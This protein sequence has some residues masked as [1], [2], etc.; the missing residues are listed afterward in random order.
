MRRV[1]AS[2][3]RKQI[4]TLAALLAADV[5]VLL[6]GFMIVRETAPVGAATSTP[7]ANCQSI[8]AE[9]LAEHNLAGAARLDADGGLRFELSGRDASG[10]LWPHASEVAWDA[11]PL[12]LALPDAGCGPYPVARVDVPDPGGQP[13]SRLLVEVNWIDL[14]AWGKGELDDGE[15]AARVKAASYVHPEPI[16]P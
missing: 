4:I 13:G 11:L 6:A 7:P 8:G 14:R 3:T 12:A 5:A 15:L 10:R 2:L 9:L 16:R 1:F